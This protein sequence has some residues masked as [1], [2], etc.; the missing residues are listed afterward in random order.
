MRGQ[1][2][3]VEDPAEPTDVLP[4]GEED[5]DTALLLTA[6]IDIIINFA[7]IQHIETR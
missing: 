4:T 1:S 5:E 3:V 6:Q 7:R 2:K